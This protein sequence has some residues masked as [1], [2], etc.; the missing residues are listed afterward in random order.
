MSLSRAILQRTM[1]AFATLLHTIWDNSQS[2]I[3]NKEVK[4]KVI[5]VWLHCL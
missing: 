2:W 3:M 1:K 4:L 5:I